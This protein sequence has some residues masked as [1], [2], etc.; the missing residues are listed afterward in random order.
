MISLEE[1]KENLSEQKDLTEEE[2]LKLETNMENLAE[3][4]FNLWLEDRNK[5]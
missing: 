3:I 1:F 2:I 5:K 4:L